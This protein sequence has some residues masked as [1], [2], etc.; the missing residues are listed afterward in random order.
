MLSSANNSIFWGGNYYADILPQSTHWI[1][2]DKNNTMPTFGDCELAWTSFIR[3]SVKKYEITY[4]GLI[5]KEK[6]RYHPT[7]KPLKLFQE[8]LNDYSKDRQIIIDFYH[9][10]GTTL[11][12]CQ[13]LCRRGRAIEISPAYVSVTL[14]R[15][16]QAFPGIEIKRIDT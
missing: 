2:W 11:V 12:A 16:S 13:N 3:K 9:G 5:G 7:Q 8:C 10:S 15:M 4:N 14:E 1:V 6:E